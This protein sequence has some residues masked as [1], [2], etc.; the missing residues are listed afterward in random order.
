MK[1]LHLILI[2]SLSNSIAMGKEATNRPELE[3]NVWDKANSLITKNDLHDMSDEQ[4]LSLIKSL[5]PKVKDFDR[6]L[7]EM[8][9]LQAASYVGEFPQES[10]DALQ[11]FLY[12]NRKAYEDAGNQLLKLESFYQV[13]DRIPSSHRMFTFIPKVTKIVIANE[14]PPKI[15]LKAFS[16]EEYSS[17]KESA[18]SRGGQ[19]VTDDPH[20]LRFSYLTDAKACTTSF[21]LSLQ[22]SHPVNYKVELT[23]K[24]FANRELLLKAIK[25]GIDKKLSEA[26]EALAAVNAGLKKLNDRK[27]Q[28]ISSR[29][30]EV[31]DNIGTGAADPTK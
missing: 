4:K 2:L 13:K 17:L 26:K 8:K 20:N 7:Q 28:E 14:P 6:C 27:A 29:A 9:D 25:L 22:L 3:I 10:F 18:V 5:R 31:E 24:D 30:K 23:R 19:L 21:Y 16:K 12:S 11:K 1:F 15:E